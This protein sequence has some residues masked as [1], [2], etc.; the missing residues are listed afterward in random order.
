MKACRFLPITGTREGKSY[1]TSMI[2]LLYRDP[3]N[4]WVV[5]PYGVSLL[6]GLPEGS[7]GVAML[8]SA[9]IGDPGERG[10]YAA[11]MSFLHYGDLERAGKT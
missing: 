1:G 2:S 7:V 11:G 3:E 6:W 10:A 8:M 4:T 5:W 9:P